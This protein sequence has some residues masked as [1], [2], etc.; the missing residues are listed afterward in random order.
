MFRALVRLGDTTLFSDENGHLEFSDNYEN[1]KER[2]V[3]QNII[4]Y[5]ENE[6]KRLEVG[7]RSPIKPKMEWPSLSIGSV[8]AVAIIRLISKSFP[9]DPDG[10]LGMFNS[11]FNTPTHVTATILAGTVFTIFIGGVAIKDY[12]ARREYKNRI[13]GLEAA[14]CKC[15]KELRKE[16]AKLRELEENQQ[17]TVQAENSSEKEPVVEKIASGFEK[18]GAF[19]G[20]YIQVYK[21]VGSDYA[22]YA[23]AWKNGELEELLARGNQHAYLPFYEEAIKDGPDYRRTSIEVPRLVKKI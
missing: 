8:V 19:A 18:V 2:F 3:Q 4:E 13:N 21:N 7:K 11:I 15:K 16:R 6:I 5:Y 17:L 20:V 22:R 9:Q 14:I 1:L 10:I 12:Q 23:R